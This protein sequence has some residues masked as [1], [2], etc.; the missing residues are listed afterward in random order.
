MRRLDRV[1]GLSRSGRARAMLSKL[2]RS[3]GY[4]EHTQAVL[5]EA[6]SL[7]R[8]QE[9]KAAKDTQGLLNLAG[10]QA[11]QKRYS[12]ALVTLDL[13][14]SVKPDDVSAMLTAGQIHASL[15]QYPKAVELLERGLMIAPDHMTMLLTLAQIYAHLS[16]YREAFDVCRRALR[17]DPN[18]APALASIE[19][20]IPALENDVDYKSIEADVIDAY[21]ALLKS[22]ADDVAL[23]LGLGVRVDARGAADAAVQRAMTAIQHGGSEE[24]DGIATPIA[25]SG[26]PEPELRLDTEWQTI[27][28][29]SVAISENVKQLEQEN[30]S[31]AT[32]I[33]AQHRRL[34]YLDSLEN[35]ARYEHTKI[36]FRN[37][38][39][40]SRKFGIP[41]TRATPPATVPDQLRA[42]YS[43]S[44]R[45][46]IEDGYLN[47]AFPPECADSISD[48][49]VYGHVL[50]LAKKYPDLV[51]DHSKNVMAA[52]KEKSKLFENTLA[53]RAY[54]PKRIV[55]VTG[56]QIHPERD[57]FVDAIRRHDLAGRSVATFT[58]VGPWIEAGCLLA[59]AK[60]TRIS[61][62]PVTSQATLLPC[63]TIT[64]SADE[65]GAFDDAIAYGTVEHQGLGRLGDTLDP[66]GDRGLM[67]RLA[68]MLRPNGRL[69]VFLP[70]GKDVV[71]FNA[72]RVYGRA[73]L[74]FLLDGWRIVDGFGYSAS[75]LDT[76]GEQ[77]ALLVLQR[78]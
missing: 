32:M 53:Q 4:R 34:G 29:L 27:S 16:R 49:D 22:R 72:G 56:Q 35:W 2:R 5:S 65:R 8:A 28:Q 40:Y 61:P 51:V 44:G 23:W 11:A 36:N 45:V 26:I 12:D 63:M 3:L 62:T 25:T 50:S 19:Q 69:F 39:L 24:S 13:Y 21:A 41:S 31:W 71:V 18:C 68:T 55:P 77:L 70:L 9:L 46:T 7:P 38:G 76:A 1:A 43:M 20:I 60:P 15:G 67:D 75:L 64:G 37:L 78:A 54:G 14:I 66:D 33:S 59:G 30:T 58:A 48:D 47:A 73:R 52:A 42:G 74:P 17:I 10:N 57:C 6:K